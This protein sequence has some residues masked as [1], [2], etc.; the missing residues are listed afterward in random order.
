MYRT[1]NGVTQKLVFCRYKVINGVK[2]YPKKAKA[3][4]FWVD[5]DTV[6]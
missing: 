6:K 5:I 2:I 4:A 1:L 3:F